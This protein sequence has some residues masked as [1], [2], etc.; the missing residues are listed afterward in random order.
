MRFCGGA[1]YDVRQI[2]FEGGELAMALGGA[3]GAAQIELMPICRTRKVISV[4]QEISETF[5]L[6]LSIFL[7]HLTC[8]MIRM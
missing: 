3:D 5:F 4:Q 7:S 8:S 6:H 2:K 1:A